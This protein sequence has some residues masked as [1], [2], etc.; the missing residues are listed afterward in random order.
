MS[1][2]DG[3]IGDSPEVGIVT[4]FTPAVQPPMPGEKCQ[5]CGHKAPVKLSLDTASLPVS[6]REQE[7]LLFDLNQSVYLT[8][9]A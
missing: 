3:G 7:W 9:P 4:A 6:K 8:R 1:H 5:T 2:N